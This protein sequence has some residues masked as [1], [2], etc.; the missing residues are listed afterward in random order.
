M[1]GTLYVV[2]VPIGNLEDIT[3][4]AM[5][6]LRTADRIACE[7]TRRTGKLL[8][9]LGLPKRPLVSYHAHNEARRVPELLDALRAGQSVAVVSDAGTPGISDPGER[10]VRAAI[11][12]SLPV[13]P[14]PGPSAVISALCASGLPTDRFRFIGFLPPK[15]EA[16]RRTLESLRTDPDTLVFYISPHRFADDLTDAAEVLGP[17]RPAVVAREITKL[18]E[19]FRREPLGTLAADPRD[20]RGEIVLMVAGAPAAA[21]PDEATLE[22]LIHQLVSDGLS[23]SQAAKEAARQ[24]GASRNEAYRV[25]MNLKGG[26]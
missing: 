9:L 26:E 5:R 16:R 24:T 20:P 21:P 15:R 10:L 17:E 7:D 18:F 13:V 3:L 6:I 19:E 8:E 22:A 2:A 14:I 1:S 12:A 25:A 23:P 4:R 11:D